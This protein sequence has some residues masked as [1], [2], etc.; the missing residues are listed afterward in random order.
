VDKLNHVFHRLTGISSKLTEQN[1]QASKQCIAPD[2]SMINDNF[3]Q[4]NI[5]LETIHESDSPSQVDVLEEYSLNPI[6]SYDS[7]F[8]QLVTAARFQYARIESQLRRNYVESQLAETM[9]SDSPTSEKTLWALRLCSYLYLQNCER[10]GMVSLDPIA[11]CGIVAFQALLRLAI[12]YAATNKHSVASITLIKVRR[13]IAKRIQCYKV[14]TS[15]SLCAGLRMKGFDTQQVLDQKHKMERYTRRFTSALVI[16]YLYQSQMNLEAVLNLILPICTNPIAKRITRYFKF[17]VSSKK[18][19]LVYDVLTY[20]LPRIGVQCTPFIARKLVSLKTQTQ[21]CISRLKKWY[22]PLQAEGKNRANRPK[23]RSFHMEPC[24]PIG[25]ISIVQND[26][27]MMN[28]NIPTEYTLD[29]ATSLFHRGLMNLEEFL[30]YLGG[31][32][33]GIF[34]HV[35]RIDNKDGEFVQ[36]IYNLSYNT[37]SEVLYVFRTINKALNFPMRRLYQ[38]MKRA[39]KSNIAVVM[40]G[41]QDDVLHYSM[42]WNGKSDEISILSETPK[43]LSEIFKHK[44]LCIELLGSL[45]RYRSIKAQASTICLRNPNRYEPL[46]LLLAPAEEVSEDELSLTY[47]LDGKELQTSI[48][49]VENFTIPHLPKELN[50][51]SNVLE[52]QDDTQFES[53]GYFS[54]ATCALNL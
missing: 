31:V 7:D 20:A 9:I 34:V 25:S 32:K 39:A 3:N 26:E 37:K 6:S 35:S 17:H 28:P 8:A 46:D 19:D 36:G 12:G 48:P 40:V 44:K 24:G 16:S 47:S 52:L 13:E 14:A 43:D 54:Q 4:L 10:L 30:M 5:D 23:I 21:S 50:F 11:Y 2:T 51:I 42:I 1:V 38:L 18:S 53:D 15:A 41:R 33:R 45:R 27:S 49:K 29:E 22:Q